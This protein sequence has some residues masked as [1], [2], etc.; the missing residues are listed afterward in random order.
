M[1]HLLL[2]LAVVLGQSVLAADK[3]PLIADPYFEKVIRLHIK[4]PTGELTKADLEKVRRL[5]LFN[6]QI[7]DAGLKEV[8]KLNRLSWLDL[9]GTKITDAGLKEVA[10][11]QNLTRLVLSNTQITDAGLKELVKCK[12]LRELYP[13]FSK[14]TKAGIEQLQKALPKCEVDWL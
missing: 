10:K 4:K 2:I 12:Q 11:L 5:S 1:Q 9:Q 14:V 13:R 6:T 3:E 8:A 7:T